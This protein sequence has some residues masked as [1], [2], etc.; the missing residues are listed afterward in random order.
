MGANGDTIIRPD[1]TKIFTVTSGG[2][3]R[4]FLHREPAT[5]GST[6]RI[7]YIQEGDPTSRLWQP[8]GAIPWWVWAVAIGALFCFL[9]FCAFYLMLNAKD[10]DDNDIEAPRRQR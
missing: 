2:A 3:K 4:Y 8:S 9:G 7:H 5:A 6:G 1:G 10:R